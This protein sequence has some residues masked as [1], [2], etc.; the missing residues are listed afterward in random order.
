[1]SSREGRGSLEWVGRVRCEE[2]ALPSAAAYLQIHLGHPVTV[3][4]NRAV[5]RALMSPTEKTSQRDDHVLKLLEI[6]LLLKQ[7]LAFFYKDHGCH[8]V[9]SP[10]KR[11]RV[12]EHL[13]HLVTCGYS[14]S[15]L[16]PIFSSSSLYQSKL[17]S[18]FSQNI[19]DHCQTKAS[20]VVWNQ[21]HGTCTTLVLVNLSAF[22]YGSR[23]D[24]MN[25]VRMSN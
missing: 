16:Q 13:L 4:V 11:V 25:T 12:K 21:L 9:T 3:I 24:M 14:H 19:P 20:V 23:E 10:C 15:C 18:L 1:M 7:V 17:K 2:H 5:E 22:S 6:L 8:L